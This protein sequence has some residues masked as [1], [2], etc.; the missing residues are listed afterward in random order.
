LLP[1]C[2]RSSRILAFVRFQQSPS[3]LYLLNS[4][5][6]FH[7]APPYAKTGSVLNPDSPDSTPGVLAPLQSVPPT[8]PLPLPSRSQAP[9]WERT[10]PRLC[11]ACSPASCAA[12]P[13]YVYISVYTAVGTCKPRRA[14]FRNSCPVFSRGRVH[15]W[16]DLSPR[17][18]TTPA[19]RRYA[20]QP[21]RPQ[22][23]QANDNER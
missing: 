5:P 21:A 9:A 11:L 14:D 4:Y 15:A 17:D 8:S 19:F 3:A 1:N 16:F 6:P 18:A 22:I 7:H 2:Q 23:Q 20:P 13:R 12:P 10:N